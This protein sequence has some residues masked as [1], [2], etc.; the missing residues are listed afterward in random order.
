[1]GLKQRLNAP[2][3]RLNRDAFRVFACHWKGQEPLRSEFCMSA[4]EL[5]ST[6][7]LVCTFE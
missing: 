1:L 5:T 4:A 3:D 2:D 6:G 7:S